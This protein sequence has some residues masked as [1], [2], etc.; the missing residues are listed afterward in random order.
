MSAVE[1]DSLTSMLSSTLTISAEPRTDSTTGPVA[2]PSAIQAPNV[3]IV[4]D[5]VM[6]LHLREGH[7]EHPRRVRVLNETLQADGLLERCTR[8]TP[9]LAS[10]DELLMC[11]TKEHIQRVD[12]LYM[13]PIQ[14]SDGEPAKQEGDTYIISEDIFCNRHTS[15]ATRSAAGCAAQAVRAVLSGQVSTAFAVVRPPGHH[16]S[17]NDLEG[18]CF[19]NNIAV[20]AHVALKEPGLE[21]VLIFD[22]DVSVQCFILLA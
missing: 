20:A 12:A 7:P 22:W 16:A 21:R 2:T 3:G 1:V 14:I 4:Y 17:S 18:F 8:L 15:T 6:E 10:D 11:H 5:A 19:F 9:K 13:N